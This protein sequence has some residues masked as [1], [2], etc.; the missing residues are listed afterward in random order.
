MTGRELQR[1]VDLECR[2]DDLERLV[3]W[4]VRLHAGTPAR[5][6]AEMSPGVRNNMPSNF[7]EFTAWA[8][9]HGLEDTE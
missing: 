3:Q 6:R 1:V 8:R 5:I 7:E 9:L 4:L 2:V